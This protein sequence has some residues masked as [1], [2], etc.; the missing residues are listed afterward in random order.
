MPTKFKIGQRVLCIGD[1]SCSIRKYKEEYP[2][3]GRTYTIRGFIE[4]RG[5]VGILLEEIVNPEY[6]YSDGFNEVA[7]GIHNFRPTEYQPAIREIL[8]RFQVTE[9]RLDVRITKELNKEKQL[10]NKTNK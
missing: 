2:V 4:Y 10:T 6:Q 1:F 9:E 5:Q 3:K 7:F 8:E